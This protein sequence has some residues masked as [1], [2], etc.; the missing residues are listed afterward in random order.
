MLKAANAL[1]ITRGVHT[2]I[3]VVMAFS[4]FAVLWAGI[5]GAHGWWLWIAST[6]VAIEIA[7]FSGSGMKCPLTAVAIR[8]GSRPGADT[9]FPEALTRHTLHFFG[10]MIVLGVILLLWRWSA[11]AQ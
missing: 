8:Y 6:L 10:P 3:Y 9:F 5:T 4:V 7:I 1:R 2:A 11:L